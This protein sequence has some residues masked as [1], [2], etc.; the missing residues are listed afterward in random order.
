[1]KNFKKL[2]L[3]FTLVMAV[4]SCDS[5]DD[6]GFDNKLL[7]TWEVSASEDGMEIGII[8]QFNANDTGELTTLLSFGGQ[9]VSNESSDFSYSVDG[10]QLTMVMGGE[11]DISTFS[12]SGDKLTI[13]DSDGEAIVLTKI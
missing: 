9:V 1:M 11:T 13:T 5:D 12:V 2:I 10:N 4:A 6:A 3:M 7:G 8:A